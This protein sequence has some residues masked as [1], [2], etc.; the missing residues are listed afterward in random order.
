VIS[1]RAMGLF[2][3]ALE[4][5]PQASLIRLNYA[6]ALIK[7]GKNSEAKERTRSARQAG[8]QVPGAGRSRAVAQG[9]LG[10]RCD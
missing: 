9:A 8:R 6:K 10:S 3:K 4:L 5:A 2:K 7:A 1:A